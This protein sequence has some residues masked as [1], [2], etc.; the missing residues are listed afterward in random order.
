M[1]I[2]ATMVEPVL[3]REEAGQELCQTG[4]GCL[5]EK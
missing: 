1:E 5:K 3:W 2:T 4:W